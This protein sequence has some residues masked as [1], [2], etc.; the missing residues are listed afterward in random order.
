MIAIKNILCPVDFSE[1]SSRACDYAFS[2]AHRYEAKVFLQNVVEPLAISYPTF[3]YPESLEKVYSDMTVESRR[4]LETLIGENG[5]PGV[6]S[7]ILVE[8]GPVAFRILKNAEEK[9]IDLIVMGTHGRQGL[10]HL[11]MGSVTEK[12]MRNARCPVLVVPSGNRK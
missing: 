10:M 4:H 3:T 1:F 11:A 5:L 7:E 12:V 6:E 9:N 8:T 2:L